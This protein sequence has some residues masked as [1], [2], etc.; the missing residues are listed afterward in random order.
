MP[1]VYQLVPGSMIARMWFETIIPPTDPTQQD[2]VGGETGYLRNSCKLMN[3]NKASKNGIHFLDGERSNVT[4]GKNMIGFAE[5][6][7]TFDRI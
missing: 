2:G 3:E 7:A 5:V 4:L 6:F 1:A